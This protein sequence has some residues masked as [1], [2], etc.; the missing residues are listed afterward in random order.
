MC[1]EGETKQTI[2]DEALDNLALREGVPT[3]SSPVIRNYGTLSCGYETM[4]QAWPTL[5]HRFSTGATQS[6][7]AELHHPEARCKMDLLKTCPVDLLVVD[8]GS[9]R[10]NW[11]QTKSGAGRWEQLVEATPDK[12]RPWVILESWPGSSVGWEVSP[13]HKSA[14]TRW[15]KRGCSSRHKLINSLH[16]G[17]AVRQTRLMVA[18]VHNTYPANWE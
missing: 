9:A 16:C 10:P 14:M 7:K 6:H 1:V 15:A 11:N 5:H 17:G 2:G 13:M 18:R 3:S 8:Q 12:N 4:T